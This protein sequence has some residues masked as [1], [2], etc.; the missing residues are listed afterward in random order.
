MVGELFESVFNIASAM[1]G[2][3]AEKHK[4]WSNG[5]HRHKGYYF[6]VWRGKR[7]K[8]TEVKG[9]GT[10]SYIRRKDLFKKVIDKFNGV[11][12]AERELVLFGQKLTPACYP[13]LRRYG[14]R[15]TRVKDLEVKILSLL[16]EGVFS[17]DSGAECLPISLVDVLREGGFSLS[18]MGVFGNPVVRPSDMSHNP[19]RDLEYCVL[20]ALASRCFDRRHGH[21]GG[22]QGFK[23]KGF[24]VESLLTRLHSVLFGTSGEFSD[25]S[26]VVLTEFILGIVSKYN[27]AFVRRSDKDDGTIFFEWVSKKSTVKMRAKIK[28]DLETCKD[29]IN[30]FWR[31]KELSELA[32][33]QNTSLSPDVNIPSSRAMVVHTRGR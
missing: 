29:R 23:G 32:M 25:K 22:I 17:S 27:D 33:S 8:C 19:F 28:K 5:E 11:P 16:V 14:V 21:R 12:Y 9:G 26:R 6:D 1:N 24:S 15:V 18:D 4:V 20:S 31:A 13:L 10:N 30:E 3:K 7:H 2:A